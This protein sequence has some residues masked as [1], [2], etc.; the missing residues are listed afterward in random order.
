M[1]YVGKDFD[2][3]DAIVES[4]TIAFDFTKSRNDATDPIVS[5][6]WD[7]AVTHGIDAGAAGRLSAAQ[8]TGVHNQIAS[9]RISGL[10]GGVKYRVM[11]EATFAAGDTQSLWSYIQGIAVP[12]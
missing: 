3:M 1:A 5:V 12:P 9:T 7:I 2:P 8:I 11:A 6:V 4:E 10:L